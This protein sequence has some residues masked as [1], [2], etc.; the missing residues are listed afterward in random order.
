M[1]LGV[2]AREQGQHSEAQTCL[3]RGLHIAAEYGDVGAKAAKARRRT[4]SFIRKRT[5]PEP[6]RISGVEEMWTLG[7]L[8][9]IVLTRDV[10]M[11]RVEDLYKKYTRPF[12]IP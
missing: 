8:I 1:N 2:V 5:M 3:D 7:Y 6:Q 12:W 4:P 9:D 10:W 11:H